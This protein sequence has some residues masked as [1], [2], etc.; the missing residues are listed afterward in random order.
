MRYFAKK[1]VSLLIFIWVAVT[2]NFLIPRLMPGNPAENLIARMKGRA[3]PRV[4][5]AL[6]LQFGVTHQ[7]LWQQYGIYLNHLLHGQLG[8][9]TEYYPVQVST[10]IA[11]SLP[12]TLGLVGVTTVLAFVIGT[13]IGILSAWRRNQLFDTIQGLLWMFL[14]AI[15]QFWLALLML[16]FFAFIKG[17]FPLDHSYNS[18][19]IPGFT[20]SFIGNVL[21][22]AMLPG[23][24][25]LITSIGGWMLAM[26]NNMIQVV[27]DDFVGYARA[28]GLKGRKIMLTYAARNA[29]LPSVTQFAIA[30]GYAVGGQI[31]IETIFSYPGIG[32]QLSSAVS[33]QDYPLAQGI[34]LIIA[35]VMSLSNFLVDLLYARLDPRVRVEVSAR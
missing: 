20:F 18:T 8:I 29:I 28:K 26:R 23:L 10:I 25:L 9:S 16:W 6:K 15:P 11:Q 7:P 33:S 4:L 32:F 35:I 5:N 27:S 30:L 31:L 12:W 17:W 19:A 22:H 3:D 14:G 21:W 13:L 1:L 34:F 2:L 24:A